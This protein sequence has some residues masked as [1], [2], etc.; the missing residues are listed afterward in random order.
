MV[1][2]PTTNYI[3]CYAD[4]PNRAMEL[5]NGGSQQ[6]NNEQCQQIASQQG[7]AYYGLQDST[8]GTKGKEDI[9]FNTAFP[10]LP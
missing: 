10:I 8:S 3:G 4:N 5:Y 1:K 6:Y 2:N 7:Y 9:P